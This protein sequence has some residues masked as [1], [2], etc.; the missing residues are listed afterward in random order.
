MFK[1]F[2]TD[3]CWINIKWGILE[4]N[5][6]PVLYIGRKV[7]KVKHTVNSETLI[8]IMI[9]ENILKESL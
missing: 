4:G 9:A 7:H 5:F 3:I 8:D 1:I 2:S 6:T